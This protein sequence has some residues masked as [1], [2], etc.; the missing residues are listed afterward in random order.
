MT[1]VNRMGL[2]ALALLIGAV[3]GAYWLNQQ[4][5]AQEQIDAVADAQREEAAIE[6]AARRKA[7]EEKA[8]AL[9]KVAQAQQ[10][11]NGYT[12]SDDDV[13]Q[14]CAK[15]VFPTS[16][17]D[18]PTFHDWRVDSEL[19]DVKIVTVQVGMKNGMGADV[20]FIAVCTYILKPDNTIPAVARLA[21]ASD[22]WRAAAQK[23]DID[24]A[25][26]WTQLELPKD[27]PQ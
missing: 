13:K 12:W 18:T 22:V 19:Q 3:P 7:D 1:R 14:Q 17:F 25:P 16:R 27:G 6:L 26:I 21:L 8:E 20:A 4:R 24:H 9:R 11:K 23:Q 5:Q 10:L 2:F 15:A